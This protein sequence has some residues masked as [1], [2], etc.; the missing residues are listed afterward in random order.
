[1]AS[2]EACRRWGWR[3]RIKLRETPPRSTID[4]DDVIGG[5]GCD[6]AGAG[7][8]DVDGAREEGRGRV[9][10]SVSSWRATRDS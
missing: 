5:G 2:S 6:W 10:R 9:K 1:V 3:D 7:P 4:V 8:P